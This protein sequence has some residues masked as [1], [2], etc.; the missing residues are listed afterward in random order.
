VEDQTIEE[1]GKTEKSESL[2][3]DD[4][5]DFDPAPQTDTPNVANFDYHDDVQDHIANDSVDGNDDVVG[6]FGEPRVPLRRSSIQRLS[7]THYSFNEW[8]CVSHWQG[9]TRML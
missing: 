4:V 9:R 8:I 5:V 1:I 6:D 3:I 7:S 2:S